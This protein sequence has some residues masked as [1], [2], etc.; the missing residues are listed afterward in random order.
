M[1]HL[2]HT[3]MGPQIHQLTTHLQ[4]QLEIQIFNCHIRFYSKCMHYSKHVS[5]WFVQ[6][7]ERDKII[8]CSNQQNGTD[9]VQRRWMENNSEYSWT[10]QKE[11]MCVQE[12]GGGSGG[13]CDTSPAQT[14]AVKKTCSHGEDVT[15]HCEKIH[16]KREWDR[17]K[18]WNRLPWHSVR[19]WSNIQQQM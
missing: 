13:E 6:T 18:M 1:Q 9:V 19:S 2:N 14:A 10:A 15:K 16:L 17:K 4:F 7:E 11:Q 3:M 12:A 8:V 5:H